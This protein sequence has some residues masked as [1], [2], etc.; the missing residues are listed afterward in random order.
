[1]VSDMIIASPYKRL[2]V[3]LVVS[4]RAASHRSTG[5]NAKTT[6]FIGAKM[7][8]A[9]TIFK[10]PRLSIH[11]DLAKAGLYAPDTMSF[12]QSKAFASP[13]AEIPMRP[14]HGWFLIVEKK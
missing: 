10:S 3:C 12:Q 8:G 2:G 9:V 11:N 13:D 7:S 1:M 6:A 14:T 5:V 4:W